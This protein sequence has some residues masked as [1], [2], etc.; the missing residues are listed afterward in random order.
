MYLE[1]TDIYAR[2][3]PRLQRAVER[4]RR[5]MRTVA[6][7]SSDEAEIGVLVLVED[8]EQFAARG[9]VRLGAV[10]GE[11]DG[12]WLVTARVPLGRIETIRQAEGVRSMKSAQPMRPVLN[13]TV[14]E[15][16]ADQAALPPGSLAAGGAGVVVGIIDS[17][18]DFAHR[19]F[20]RPDGS[21]RLVAL[22]HQDGPSTPGSPFGY[23][24]RYTAADI[25]LALSGPNPYDALGYGPAPDVIGR[26]K[27]T[28]GTHVSDIAAGNGGGSGATGVAHEADIAFVEPALSDIAWEGEDVVNSFFGDSVQQLEAAR[29][30]FDEAGA[31]PCV[32]NI[33]L[34]TNGGPHDGSSLVEKGLDALVAQRPN[35]A[36]VIAAGNAFDDGVHIAGA[37]PAGGFVDV[38]LS[39]PDGLVSQTEME[40]WYAGGD[41]F[42]AELI[43]PAGESLGEVPLGSNARVR[44]DDG[45]TLL[46]VSHRADDPNNGDNM[47][48]I[49]LEERVPAGVWQ[50]RL[51]GE[52]V[53]DGGYHAWIERNDQSQASFVDADGSGTLGSISCGRLT[54]TVGSYDAH[55]AA[56]PLSFF[57]AA[58]PT[59]D[60]RQK[61]EISA[62]GQDVFAAHSRTTTGVVRKSGTSMA[63][64]AA[65]GVVALILAEAHARGIALDA[66]AL[67]HIVTDSARSGPPPAGGWDDR[68]GHGRIDAA[69]ALRAVQRLAG[70]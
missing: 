14:P 67:R 7:A 69:E 24:K 65:T 39:I 55:K 59:R 42:T 34:G 64:P 45:T 61:P 48:S 11:V 12:G 35:R 53:A 2:M 26:P 36:V 63:A 51:H 9:D 28:H 68:Y 52:Q 23:G 18:A 41:R 8:T 21:T 62:P 46:F 3:D 20:L 66:A 16:E 13:A 29:F 5:G 40:L 15:I 56:K 70:P 49:F 57:S 27:G 47:F 43:T 50:V 54:L 58:G 10:I 31:R 37:V 19:N 33:S 30:L 32:I 25:D 22:W 17:G 38:G 4:R 1:T 44:A 60:G 6:T